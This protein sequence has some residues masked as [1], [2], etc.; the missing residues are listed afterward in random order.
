M[1]EGARNQILFIIS[2]YVY[3]NLSCLI[4]RYILVDWLVEVAIM[5]VDFLALLL[6]LC[7]FYSCIVFFFLFA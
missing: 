6:L 3:V 2:K 1:S 4:Y 7:K 5:K